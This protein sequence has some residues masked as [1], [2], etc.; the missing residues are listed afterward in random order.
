MSDEALGIYLQDHLA[1]AAGAV[2]LLEALQKRHAG[3]PVAELAG[4]ILAEVE[5]D[6][7]VL[8]G[9]AERLGG[10]ESHPVKEAAAWLAEKATR[11]KI[12]R[13]TA[14]E[15]GAFEALEAL[16]L[17]IWGKRA[18]WRA[19]AVLAATDSRLQGLD[20]DRLITGAESQ[21]ARVEAFR[22]RTASNALLARG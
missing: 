12:G 16:I 19:L 15:L 9:L 17:G 20:L 10:G 21:H 14:G 2:E 11:V 22:L 5:Q 13:G 4:E 7:S 1:G 18:L 3:E 8:R 6:R